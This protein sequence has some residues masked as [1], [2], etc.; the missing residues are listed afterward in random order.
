M[1]KYSQQRAIYILI[2]S[3]I[4]VLYLMVIYSLPSK[5]FLDRDFYILYAEYSD[6]VIKDFTSTISMLVNEPVFL[7]VAKSFGVTF[8]ADSFPTA[9][10]LLVSA[11]FLYCLTTQSKTSIVWFLG[12]LQLIFNPYLYA[13]QLMVL[14]QGVATAVFLYV[15]LNFKDEKTKLLVCL[16]LS[17]FHSIFFLVTIIYF[18]YIFF[19]KHRSPLQIIAITGV[20][21]SII[22]LFS[23]LI[24]STLGFRQASLYSGVNET[25][26]G[27]A[28]V[29]ALITL[30]YVYFFGAKEKKDLFNWSLIG[31]VIFLT[32]YFLFFSPGRLFMTFFPFIFILLV[33]KSRFE[34]IVFLSFLNI[35]YMY[36]FYQGTYIALFQYNSIEY[37]DSIFIRHISDIFHYL[38]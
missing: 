12:F 3:V 10:S 5:W 1:E 9:M 21:S 35:V 19:L 28:F 20:F 23:K 37:I 14:R 34:D 16:F 11:V 18:A 13:P 24:L 17:F 29:L 6:I 31:L 8:G 36:L 27:G 22:F 7:F 38:F 15:F 2:T 26:G 25:G 32:S 30:L 4:C 33:Q